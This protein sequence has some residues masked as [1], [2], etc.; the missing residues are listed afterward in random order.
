MR[1]RT[2]RQS[3]YQKETLSRKDLALLI[4]WESRLSREQAEQLLKLTESV[5]T[6]ALARGQNVNLCG[7]GQFEAKKREARGG[8]NPIT[9]ERISLDS[10]YTPKFTAGSALNRTVK[11][12]LEKKEEQK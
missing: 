3:L 12:A 1:K 11:T 9:H 6:Q 2:T 5:I 10:T 7:F 4:H 8:W